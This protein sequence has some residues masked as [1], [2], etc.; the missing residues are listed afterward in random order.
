MWLHHDQLL[1]STPVPW[2]VR[3]SGVLRVG[4]TCVLGVGGVQVVCRLDEAMTDGRMA[5]CLLLRA[6]CAYDD[7]RPRAV[8]GVHYLQRGARRPHA[9]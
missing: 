1:G 8:F 6:G 4:S 5:R 2:A 3:M 9:G 7:C